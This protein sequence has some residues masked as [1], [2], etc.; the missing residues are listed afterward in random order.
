MNGANILGFYG[1]KLLALR[2]APKLDDH[3]LSVLRDY[4]FNLFAD[5]LHFGGRFSIRNLRTRHAVLTG[6]HLF[7]ASV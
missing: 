7:W 6:A 1:E 4:V 3:P 5:T 2:P